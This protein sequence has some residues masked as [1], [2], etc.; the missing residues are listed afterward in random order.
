MLGADLDVQALDQLRS[1]DPDGSSGIFKRL[2][3][4]FLQDTPVQ[5]QKLHEAIA[6]NDSSTAAR[7]AHTIKG[8]GGNFGARRL[9]SICK[10][11]ELA[12]HA[13]NWASVQSLVPKVEAEFA[14][15]QTALTE[16]AGL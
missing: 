13:G 10:E 16:L 12:A 4:A 15:V 6:A 2:V 7:H 9:A 11:V 5:L 14:A 1:L 3:E 8:S